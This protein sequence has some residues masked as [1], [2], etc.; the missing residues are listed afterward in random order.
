MNKLQE[1]QFAILENCQ[2]HVDGLPIFYSR[3]FHYK[4]VK[5][6]PIFALDKIMILIKR[7][8]Y[9][10]GNCFGIC[11]NADICVILDFFN[12]FSVAFQTC[13]DLFQKIYINVKQKMTPSN[14]SFQ[15]LKNGFKTSKQISL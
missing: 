14:L 8:P 7:L 3:V 12:C 6:R 9:C 4:F 11:Y 1:Q 13:Q 10:F 15:T 2:S 5:S